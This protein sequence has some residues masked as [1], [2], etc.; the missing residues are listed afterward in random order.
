MVGILFSLTGCETVKTNDLLVVDFEPESSLTYKLVSS[1][2]MLI[3]FDST[4]TLPSKSK[5]DKSF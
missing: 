3:D 5:A 2:D 4:S 1:R